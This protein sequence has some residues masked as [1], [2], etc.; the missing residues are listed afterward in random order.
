MKIVN[1][2]IHG[3]RGMSP[4]FK[5]NWLITS[6]NEAVG[7]KQLCARKD[8]ARFRTARLTLCGLHVRVLCVVQVCK[9]HDGNTGPQMRVDIGLGALPSPTSALS[10]ALQDGEMDVGALTAD[11]KFEISVSGSVRYL[12]Q[13]ASAI[14]EINKTHS[15]MDVTFKRVFHLPIEARL[16]AVSQ[17]ASLESAGFRVAGSLTF[18][19][20]F[21]MLKQIKP[22]LEGVAA[23]IKT[24][25]KPDGPLDMLKRMVGTVEDALDFVQKGV[26]FGKYVTAPIRFALDSLNAITELFGLQDEDGKQIGTIVGFIEWV[27]ARGVELAAWI[28]EV[29]AE[30]VGKVADEAAGVLDTT[31][32]LSLSAK[33]NVESGQDGS[34]VDA[35]FAAT[36]FGN[37]VAFNAKLH[38]SETPESVAKTI[39]DAAVGKAAPFVA[40]I[41]VVKEILDTKFQEFLDNAKFKCTEKC[42]EVFKVLWDAAKVVGTVILAPV[43]AVLILLSHAAEVAGKLLATT[44]ALADELDKLVRVLKSIPVT[45]GIKEIDEI[46]KPI[47]DKATYL[48]GKGVKG[49]RTSLTDAKNKVDTFSQS[50]TD[51]MTDL[52]MPDELSDVGFEVWLDNGDGPGMTFELTFKDGKVWRLFPKQSR[53]RLQRGVAAITR[54]DDDSDMTKEDVWHAVE[55]FVMKKCPVPDCQK[56]YD[57]LKDSATEKMKQLEESALATIKEGYETTLGLLKHEWERPIDI[58]DGLVVLTRDGSNGKGP[59]MS[60][61][62]NAE[63]FVNLQVHVKVKLGEVVLLD[64]GAALRISNSRTE[65]AFTDMMVFSV[66]KMNGTLTVKTSG[67]QLEARVTSDAIKNTLAKVQ[68]KVRDAARDA[69]KA[70]KKDLTEKTNAFLDSINNLKCEAVADKANNPLTKE[71]IKKGCNYALLKT[72][73]EKIKE[74]VAAAVQVVVKALNAISEAATRFVAGLVETAINAVTTGLILNSMAVNLALSKEAASVAVAVDT[75]MGAFKFKFDFTKSSSMIGSLVTKMGEELADFPKLDELPDK[76]KDEFKRCEKEMQEKIDS[77]PELAKE[78]IDNIL[79]EVGDAILDYAGDKFAEVGQFFSPSPAPPKKFMIQRGTVRKPGFFTKGG[80]YSLCEGDK[81]KDNEYICNLTPCT[82]GQCKP[83]NSN[84]ITDMMS[85]AC[86]LTKPWGAAECMEHCYNYNKGHRHFEM[87]MDKKMC[88][89]QNTH[90][91]K[92]KEIKGFMGVVQKTIVCEKNPKECE[93]LIDRSRHSYTLHT[94]TKEVKKVPSGFKWKLTSKD[95][96]CKEHK[97]KHPLQHLQEN[98]CAE[99]C[100]QFNKNNEYFMYDRED[101]QCYCVGKPIFIIGS[102]AISKETKCTKTSANGI[103]WGLYSWFIDPCVEKCSD[104]LLKDF[105]D[106]GAITT[107]ST[108]LTKC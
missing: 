56:F 35:S 79:A 17:V 16:I 83:A 67:V 77:L 101:M 94:W 45:T 82:G 25:V 104:Q 24:V 13:S 105:S 51:L 50:A 20:V 31:A 88:N 47:L 52:E 49:I 91:C 103:Y 64:S 68:T 29:A 54:R 41:A 22:V 98:Q 9:W 61:D 97:Y 44:I 8:R 28:D 70:F 63:D 99:H 85:P 48:W 72:I 5:L 87:S 69:Q 59:I 7:S 95:W 3:K 78:K 15:Y 81:K 23:L 80:Y 39:G 36:L 55:D 93:A 46:I 37:T 102:L 58:A 38:S 84:S 11:L 32:V 73:I 53:R 42:K 71:A 96:G 76:F 34:S 33:F 62:P 60:I 66:F 106:F 107:Y 26:P 75:G 92:E 1:N 19:N 40:K 43:K 27:Q 18:G 108:C 21:D 2:K 10:S 65:L 30:A 57:D 90:N 89:C 14:I 4:V 86:S 74:A 12:G 100:W 6:A